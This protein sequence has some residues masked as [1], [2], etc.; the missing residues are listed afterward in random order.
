M[1]DLYDAL[2]QYSAE[3]SNDRRDD[4]PI[5]EVVRRLN[6]ILAD[7]PKQGDK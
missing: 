4:I 7:H 3:L 5:D 1:P 6:K 2:L